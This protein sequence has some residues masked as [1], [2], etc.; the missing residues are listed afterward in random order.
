MILSVFCRSVDHGGYTTVYKYGKMI[1]LNCCTVTVIIDTLLSA[2][3]WEIRIFDT[4]VEFPNA[5]L[6][7]ELGAL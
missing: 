6:K 1:D 5:N 7:S 4:H 3:R 2:L